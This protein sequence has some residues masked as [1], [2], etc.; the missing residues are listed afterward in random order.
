MI[1]Q[2]LFIL[3]A[4]RFP[5]EKAAAL[6]VAENARAF[7]TFVPVTIVV[8]RRLG[9]HA[10]DAHAT[11]GLPSSVRVVYL[12]T[13][14]LFRVP[15][16]SYVAFFIHMACFSFVTWW[17][18]IVV[19]RP[20]DVVTTNDPVLGFLASWYS[21]VIY[22]V[23]DFPDNFLFLYRWLCARSALLIATNQWKRKELIV[24]F[25]LSESKVVMERNGVDV[26]QFAPQDK[27]YARR[28][29]GLP[30]DRHIV[31]YTG[32]L[33]GWKGV[34]TLAAAARLV[35]DMDVY[36]VGGTEE[37]KGRYVAAHQ[38]ILTLHVVG[39]RPHSEIPLWL[40]VADVLVLPN[41]AHEEIS[42]HY[43]SPM[44]LFEYMASGRPI[45]ASNIPSI[46][47]VLPVHAGYF[48]CPDD[49]DSLAFS[50]REIVA[51][52]KE[53]GRRAQRAHVLVEDLSWEKRAA[54]IVARLKN[55]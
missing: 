43:T 26:A 55:V 45:L 49:P 15:L 17:Y 12:P 53:A 25:G 44:K 37:D 32:H 50:I 47:E 14:D 19:S 24:R 29:L 33:Y 27:Q 39:H 18:L 51:D 23:H 3:F 46:A 40:A 11:Y 10:G 42:S 36:V 2:R 1:I 16:L 6:F 34:D 4:E 41:T 22:E 20:G 9:R 30:P 54:R 35:P 38:D 21:P 13:L 48:F 7:T 8:P 52:S 28:V 31:I 5:S